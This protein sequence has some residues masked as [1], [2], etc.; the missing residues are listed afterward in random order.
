MQKFFSFLLLLFFILFTVNLSV[1]N[2]NI[3]GRVVDYETKE[4]LAFVTIII[5]DSRQGVLTDIDGV[6][7]ISSEKQIRKLTLSYVGYKNKT[8]FVDYSKDYH[9]LKL[10]KSITDLSEVVIV[11]G[12]N[13]AHRIIDNVIKN[14]KTNNPENRRSFTFT[15]YNKFIITSEQDLFAYRYYQTGDSAFYRINNFLEQRHFFISESVSNKRYRYPGRK[16]EEVLAN[17]VSGLKNPMVAMLTSQLQSFSFYEDFIRILDIEYVSPLAAGSKRRYLFELKDTIFSGNDSVFVIK[18][19]PFV[20]SN[21]DGMEG[22]MYINSNKWAVQNVIAKPHSFNDQMIEFGIQQ[23]YKYVDNKQWFPVQLNTDI[24]I[25]LNP[26]G[27]EGGIPLYG[28]SRSYITD[29]VLAPPLTRRDFSAFDIDYS[30][31]IFDKGEEFLEK[32]RVEALSDREVNT[33]EYVDSVGEA[34]NLERRIFWLEA[35][36]LG[37]IRAGFIDINI[38]KLY[39]YN[40]YEKH[41][42]GFGVYTNENFLQW[43]R[44]GGYYAYGTGDKE[45]K[46]MVNPEF[47]INRNRGLRFGYKFENNVN[48]RG[49][50]DFLSNNYWFQDFDPRKYYI[51]TMDVVVSDEVYLESRFLRNRLTL[52]LSGSRRNFSWHDS[53]NFTGEIDDFNV[54]EISLKS[55]FG[56]GEQ[57][58]RT[59][60]RIYRD[61]S[62]RPSLS[63]NLSRGIKGL[64]EGDF[65]YWKLEARFDYLLSIP[66]YGSQKWRL[67]TGWVS[68]PSL[69]LPLL[70]TA[71]GSMPESSYIGYASPRSFG[72]MKVDEFASDI[73]ASLFFEHNFGPVIYRSDNYAPEFAVVSNIGWGKLNKPDY[74]INT[75][76]KSMNQGYFESGLRVHKIFPKNWLRAVGITINPGIEVLYRY[77]NYSLKNN[78][79]NFA[80]K[81][82]LELI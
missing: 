31:D 1:A 70:F 6:F 71:P 58:I 21:I 36:M 4:P 12:V 14:K 34:T 80:F 44:I 61:F 46:Y 62:E 78:I 28:Q 7:S 9:L 13:P 24:K 65:D 8:Y 17:R 64:F 67:Q 42:L 33:Y 40:I 76:I 69:P 75:F 37:D 30:P 43:F 10:K 81:F 5:E 16:T 79:D 11:P 63:V 15:A 53:Y 48:E 52:N 45:H 22:V 57:F 38:N 77:G 41:R 66:F 68:N 74:H 59:P 20:N 51:R 29:I 18:Y 82:I 2:I 26:E 73:Y 54:S 56:F 60:G 50:S 3:Q 72:A 47:I 49:E 35:L 55:R 32:Y 23:K 25:S 39:S 27:L 19:R